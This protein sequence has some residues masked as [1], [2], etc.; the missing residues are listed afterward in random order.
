MMK[1]ILLAA[2]FLFLSS[3][4]VEAYSPP[5]GTGLNVLNN[6][7]TLIAPILGT[8]ASIV[9]TNGTGT[10]S[11]LTA[12]T[13]STINGLITAGSNVTVTG[14]GTSGSPYSIAASGTGTATVV[15]PETYSAVGNGNY[16]FDGAFTA[17]G[18]VSGSTGSSTTATAPAATTTT[19]SDVLISVYSTA[20]TFSSAPS[21]TSRASVTY[22]SGSYGILAVDQT[23]ASP[24]TTSAVSGTLSGSSAWETMSIALAPS[25]GTLTFEAS[26]TTS[27]TG[28]VNITINK[29]TGTAS[30]DYLVAC[31][32]YSTIAKYY[33][34]PPTGWSIISA[35]YNSSNQLLCY[36]KVAGG[37]E[38]STYTFKN[39]SNGATG[40]AG[41]IL[42]YR[43]TSGI[44]TPTYTLTSN[45]AN[46]PSGAGGDDICVASV[47]GQATGPYTNRQECGT[48]TSRSSSTAVNVN[49]PVFSSF[50]GLQF[51]YGADDTT[52]FNSMMTTAPCS[53]TGCQVQLS[54]KH[55]M[56]TGTL[57]VNANV[58][59]SFVGINPA[60]PNTANNYIN[61]VLTN[62]N[63][64]SSLVC[65]NQSQ[66]SPFLDYT[67]VGN[68]T[69]T[70]M[71]TNVNNLT[72]YGGAGIGL[73]GC[74]SDGMDAINWQGFTA[75]NVYI[76]NFA[77]NG[78]YT[79]GINAFSFKDYIE[80]IIGKQL[81]ISMNGGAGFKV[82]S[83]TPINNLENISCNDCIIEANG[84]QAFDLLGSNIQG[85]SVKNNT[86]QWDNLLNTTNTA[87]VYNAG[88]ILGGT[89]TGNY[90]EADNNFGSQSGQI[91]N[92][93][94]GISMFSNFYNAYPSP[95]SLTLNGIGVIGFSSGSGTAAGVPDTAISR[96]SAGVLDVGTGAVGN[97][98]GTINASKFNGVTIPSKTDTA[99]LLGTAESFTAGQ[100][101]TPVT[102]N[103]ST[104]T[105]TPNFA[106]SNNHNITLVHA[107]CPCTL[108]NPTNIVAG[109]SGVMV[110]NQSS[111]GS[112]LINT[113][114]TAYVFTNAAA[115]TLSTAA[116]AVDEFS[117]Y[118]VDGAH[119][120]IAP[121]TST[122][123]AGTAVTPTAGSGVTSVT[124]ASAACT[125]L[126]GTYTIVGGTATTGT[127]ASLAWTATPTAYV[128]TATMNGGATSFG[129]GNSVATTT[130]MNITAAVSV[131]SATFSVNYS[132]QP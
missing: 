98:S 78:F 38:P 4:S 86:I 14:S 132:C 53:T 17:S 66:T 119:I 129:I 109:Q 103:I 107:S 58:P 19:A 87:E 52:A 68:L 99:A 79:D 123:V 88:G 105:F 72:I 84:L 131:V 40:E 21:G 22:T 29:P 6:G 5:T 65:A 71:T 94:T 45:T 111:S 46:F 15:Y 35:D 113:Y 48:I 9:L 39:S 67:G 60:V 125:N 120:R 11:G 12:G 43:H 115:P 51:V 64:G 54:N 110:I 82:G 56:L 37:S 42:D 85:F 122:A 73:D 2:A 117:Y 27:S 90:L 44:D 47:Q 8:P 106:A 128:C 76:F 77:G 126:R 101:V 20:S 25:G 32:S 89:I 41:F 91:I 100:A 102:V 104:S 95:E 114:G 57:T 75:D 33:A 116:S 96:D 24:G 1:K 31:T 130:G 93:T 18:S 70:T 16:Y 112:D 118:V 26:S 23:I 92:S 63:A 127:V 30:G 124:C 83:S 13:V 49:F 28:S 50:T 121:L 97:K 10:A 36:E 34:A 3:F 62:S 74:G 69:N 81:Y 59:V 61:A 55:Y 7:P 80:N 108:A